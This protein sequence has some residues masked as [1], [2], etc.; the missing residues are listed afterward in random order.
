MTWCRDLIASVVVSHEPITILD[1]DDRVGRW[2]RMKWNLELI[3]EDFLTVAEL[4][5]I[6]LQKNAIRIE[7]L[8]IHAPT[9]SR[10]ATVAVDS[11]G[12]MGPQQNSA[13]RGKMI[14]AR[15]QPVLWHMLDLGAVDARLLA[16]RSL[17]RGW[18][19]DEAAALLVVL[20]DLGN[21]SSSFRAMLLDR[22]YTGLRH[23]QHSY[24][25][26]RDHHHGTLI[27][28]AKRRLIRL[29]RGSPEIR[30]LGLALTH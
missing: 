7:T 11:T 5:G 28:C 6:N 29:D 23:R 15:A 2:M 17:T 9:P 13:S 27:A 4:A 25:L 14:E 12:D 24:R 26:S 18:R 19:C 21:F 10:G 20:H 3:L 8:P 22:H 1:R 16:R 30:P